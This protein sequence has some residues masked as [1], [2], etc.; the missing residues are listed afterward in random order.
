MSVLALPSARVSQFYVAARSD[1]AREANDAIAGCDDW[2]PGR[3]E[4]V[5]RVIWHLLVAGRPPIIRKASERKIAAT[6]IRPI[7]LVIAA[8]DCSTPP[9]VKRH[10]QDAQRMIGYQCHI[11]PPLR[12]RFL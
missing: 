3:I 6:M 8:A 4:I 10:R 12:Q 7:R 9:A 11:G 5:E 1:H 2:Q